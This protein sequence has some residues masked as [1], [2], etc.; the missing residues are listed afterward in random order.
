[1]GVKKDSSIFGM[2]GEGELS[3]AFSGIKG[4]S[5]GYGSGW[6]LFLATSGLLVMETGLGTNRSNQI[7]SEGFLKPLKSNHVIFQ[8]R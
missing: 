4:N 5:F 3:F 8:N 2:F 7:K 6:D 1:M